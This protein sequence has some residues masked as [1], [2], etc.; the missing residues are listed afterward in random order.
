MQHYEMMMRA[1]NL[2]P[3]VLEDGGAFT[4]PSSGAISLLGRCSL[5]RLIKIKLGKRYEYTGTI[6]ELMSAISSMNPLQKNS[7]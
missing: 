3:R 7:A 5:K 4:S 2:S 1:R 6:S